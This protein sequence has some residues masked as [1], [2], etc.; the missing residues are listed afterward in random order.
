[1]MFIFINTNPVFIRRTLPSGKFDYSELKLK[2]ITQL[3]EL[4]LINF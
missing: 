1:M 4:F 3:D 2:T